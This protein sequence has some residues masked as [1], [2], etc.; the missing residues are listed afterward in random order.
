[1][2]MF[3]LQDNTV[4]TVRGQTCA[5]CEQ[6]VAVVS[7][8]RQIIRS[9]NVWQHSTIILHRDEAD[10]FGKSVSEAITLSELE[11]DWDSE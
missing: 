11:S 3:G 9:L 10:S 1:M 6:K 8:S 7:I 5:H 2:A 4:Y